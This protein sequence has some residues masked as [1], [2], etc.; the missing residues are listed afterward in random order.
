MWERGARHN[1]VSLRYRYYTDHRPFLPQDP[2]LGFL[3]RSEGSYESLFYAFMVSK[4]KKK[5]IYSNNIPVQDREDFKSLIHYDN[6]FRNNFKYLAGLAALFM[7]SGIFKV[8]NFGS[9][10]WMKFLTVYACYKINH[11]AFS[12]VYLNYF[13]DMVSYYYYKYQNVAVD[14]ISE[15]KDPRR[16]FIN[17]DKSVYYR[18]T[19][20]DI[21]HKSHH[22]ANQGHHDHD[23]STY[24]GPYPVFIFF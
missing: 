12:K 24:Y 14:D 17:L 1:P 9:K 3:R 18:E 15:V 11:I 4:N 20:Q 7:S 16:E 10:H 23:T 13:N 22:P 8:A 21:R 5:Y 6:I 19:S 2:T